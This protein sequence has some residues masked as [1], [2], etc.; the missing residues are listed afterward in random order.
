MVS[1]NDCKVSMSDLERLN[2]RNKLNDKIIDAYMFLVMDEANKK[3]ARSAYCISS[4][5]YYMLCN[6][7]TQIVMNWIM[8]S[9]RYSKVTR[10]VLF[11]NKPIGGCLHL[12]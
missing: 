6:F 7:G 11:I 4:H 1:Y 5:F 8:V 12:H 10:C 2:G 9:L 3:E